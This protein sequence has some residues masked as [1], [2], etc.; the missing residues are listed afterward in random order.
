MFESLDAHTLALA[1]ALGAL[2]LAV[3]MGGI[4]LAGTRDRSVM[5]WALAGVFFSIGQIVNCF[6]LAPDV[7]TVHPVMLALIN[8]SNF[9]GHGMLLLGVQVHLERRRSLLVIG[10]M[11]LVILLVV[12]LWPLMHEDAIVRISTLSLLYVGVSM[13]TAWLLWSG[14][15]SDLKP[16]RRAVAG[17]ILAYAVFLLLRMGMLWFPGARDG[18]ES[19]DDLLV[20]VLVAALLFYLFLGVAL[21]LLLFRKKEASLQYMARH[22]ALTGLHNRY[23]LEEYASRELARARRGGSR[24]SVVSFDMDMFKGVN[25]DYGHSAGDQVLREVA[26]RVCGVI[27][28]VDIAFRMGGEEFLVMLP[29]ADEQTAH[30]VAD[31]LR[32]ALIS[33]PI[34][35]R[36]Q[37]ISISA[38]FGVAEL[39]P[40]SDD[41]ERLLRRA[42]RALYLAK[43]RGRNR[44]E[45]GM[46]EGE[47]RGNG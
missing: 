29:D 6:A 18:L 43:D 8:G 36:E 10:G 7:V 20:S 28:D 13:M 40:L 35:Y 5:S 17:I 24:F 32:D 4:Y 39:S 16:Y 2:V 27:R 19:R 47:D 1:A 21:S 26:D 38:S 31:R 11:A 25:D 34:T 44:V 30:Q 9:F 14:N 12:W 33:Q 15:S 42:D 22:D 37:E 41:W 23:S 3:S 45:T 46:R